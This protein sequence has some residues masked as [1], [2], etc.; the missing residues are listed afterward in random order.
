MSYLEQILYVENYRSGYPIDNP[1]ARP[2]FDQKP[3]IA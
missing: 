2:E 1:F 3:S